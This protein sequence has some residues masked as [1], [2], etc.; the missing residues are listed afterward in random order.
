[1]S[2]TLIHLLSKA[3]TRLRGIIQAIKS[4]K[5][6]KIKGGSGF[7]SFLFKTMHE[8]SVANYKFTD[9]DYNIS[10]S[11]TKCGICVSVC[12][13][14]NI[15]IMDEKVMFKHNCERCLACI[16]WCPQKAINYKDKT[17]KKQRYHYP[18]V[19]L[20]QLQ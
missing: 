4:R 12:P 17:Q 14:K 3:D 5:G 16:H 7:L 10:E 9:K 11:C 2:S 19:K 6:R 20:S 15:E 1:V 18:K 13:A 8:K